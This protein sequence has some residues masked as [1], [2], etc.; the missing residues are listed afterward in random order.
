MS[1]T[2]TAL[3]DSAER[4][5]RRFGFDGFS[6]ADL[7]Q[8][9]GIRKASIHYH[10]PSKASLSV[11][12]MRRYRETFVG[13]CAQIESAEE[14]GVGRL[15]ALISQYESALENGTC[16]CLCVALSNS[17]DSVCAETLDQM[18][19]FRAAMMEWIGGAFALGQQDGSIA[20]VVD[21][22]K[23]AAAMLPLLEGA[24]LAAR[25][26]GDIAAFRTATALL[27]DR[28]S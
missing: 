19:Q 4:A 12:M 14:T 5:A 24:Q 26:S 2:K 20:G 15:R 17:R 22:A 25:V 3:L 10:F 11:A 9:V 8:D 18:A 7:A 23:E 21:A 13:V 1:D 27:Q 16:L 6:Y 28:L